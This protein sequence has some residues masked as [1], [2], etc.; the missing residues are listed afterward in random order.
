MTTFKNVI[1]A[2]I[3]AT[4]PGIGMANTA[5]TITN[6]CDNWVKIS[7]VHAQIGN[8]RCDVNGKGQGTNADYFL[9][10]GEAAQCSFTTT[11]GITSVGFTISDSNPLQTAEVF[12]NNVGVAVM[13]IVN[14]IAHKKG[15]GIAATCDF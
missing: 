11:H 13:P 5:L 15:G 4:V 12:V 2:S 9:Q 3:I 14:P 10:P 7:A 1:A 6:Q 8:M